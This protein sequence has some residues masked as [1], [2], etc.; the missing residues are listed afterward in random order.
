MSQLID[1]GRLRFY[2]TGPYNAS[3]PYEMND[4]VTYGGISYVYINPF[5]ESGNTPPVATHWSKL[6]EGVDYRGDWTTSTQYYVNDIVKRGGSTYI[7]KTVHTSNVF[8]TDLTNLE[9]EAFARGIRNRGP[10][11]TATAYLVDDVITDNL[12]TYI[13]IDDHTSGGGLFSAE[14]SGR[15]QLLTQGSDYLPAQLGNEGRVLTTDGTDP[16]WTGS[17]TLDSVTIYETAAI[18]PSAPAFLATLTN[19]MTVVTYDSDLSEG[20]ASGN[21]AQFAIKNYAD[22]GAAASTDFIAYADVGTDSDGWVDMGI[23]GTNFDDATYGVTGPHDGYVFMQAP[24]GTAGNGN[25]VLATGENGVQNWVVLSAGGLGSGNEQ[26]YIKPTGIEIIGDVDTQGELNVAGTGLLTIGDDA[27]TFRTNATLTNPVAVFSVDENEYAQVAFVNVNS[28]V[29]ASADYIA[30]ADNG[31]DNSGWIDMGITSSGF[32]DPSFTITGANDGYIFMEAPAGTTGKGNLVIATGGNGTENKLVFAA[33]GLLSDNEQMSITPDTNVH[34]EIATQSTSPT[35]GALTVVG[36]VGVQGNLFVLGNAN[37]DGSI[38]IGGGQF[39]SENLAVTDP[40][41]FVGDQNPGNTFDL[42]VIGED[43]R[44]PSPEIQA[45][46]TS[47]SRSASVVTVDTSSNHGF[48]A[49][50]V[51]NVNF[52]NVPQN[53]LDMN[54]TR[55]VLATPDADTFTFAYNGTNISST[56]TEGDV[57]VVTR[58]YYNGIV[59]DATD[60]IFKVFDNLDERPTTAVNFSDAQLTHLKANKVYLE[61]AITESAQAATKSYADAVAGNPWTTVTTNTTLAVRDRVFVDASGGGKIITLPA[62]PSL[63]DFVKIVD[64]AGI[65]GSNPITVARN[66]NKIMSLNEDLVIN[67]NSASVDLVYSG[68]TYG[69]RIV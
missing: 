35:S 15:W 65:S 17:P 34:I 63:G 67:I 52:G 23:T 14:P 47:V 36:G 32:S 10:W 2:F 68:S 28:G 19:P 58:A 51:V 57:M 42:G 41:V 21:F 46:P 22:A 39:A 13:C 16:S 37:I 33:G 60:G 61:G 26:M 56:V 30:Y 9:W 54:G 40:F 7:A 6:V 1:L 11:A 25:L 53:I 27:Q 24:V 62:S 5:K 12:D 59:R 31:D 8:E 49:G 20:A 18:G 48:I 29:N 64:V 43:R 55:T 45:Y 4:V 44:A 3:T 50:D 66:G 38:T 69:W